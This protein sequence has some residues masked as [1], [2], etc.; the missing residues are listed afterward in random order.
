MHARAQVARDLGL[1]LYRA[2]RGGCTLARTPR[3][4]GGGHG[5]PGP[6]WAKLGGSKLL[7]CGRAKELRDHH[8][9][10]VDGPSW[11]RS[12]AKAEWW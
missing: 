11:A 12:G 3:T 5:E 8:Q 9:T 4:D 2:L 1:R 6:G 10:S 7:G